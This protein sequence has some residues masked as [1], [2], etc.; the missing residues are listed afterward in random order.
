MK[1][2]LILVFSDLNHDARVVRQINFLNDKYTTTVV[3]FDAPTN[4]NVEVIRIK[5]IKPRLIQK[6]ITSFF[7]LTRLFENAFQTLYDSP[8]LRIQLKQREFDL[9]IANDIECLPLAMRI[10]KSE[11]ILFDAHEFAPRHFEDKLVWRVFFQRFNQYLCK[12]YLPLTDA[13]LTVGEGLAKEY[14]KF[15]PVNPI[16]LTNANYYADLKPLPVDSKSIKLI[17]H[18][19][20]NP[21]RQLE[22]MIEMMDY[23]DE[24]F[25]LDLM[26]LTPSIANKKT[27][28][29][30]KTLKKQI[31]K[32]SRIKIID[33]VKSD[34]VVPHIHK[35]DMGI[36][37]LPPINFNYA[38]TLPNKFFDYVQARLAIAI[39]PTPEMAKLVK[40]YNL[41][42][43]SDD[44]T[45]PSLAKKINS[46]S[47]KEISS[48]KENANQAADVLSA[49]KNKKILNDLVENLLKD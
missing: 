6:A 20:A 1:K 16:I 9:I 36:F 37:L 19:A 13:M 5:R 43:V 2:I 12:K 10:K 38:N 23:V 30:L 33:P 48:Y 35:Y 28:G 39:G 18:G 17:H 32:N 8:S 27:R 11:K 41:G 15:Y 44:F 24:R 4:L 45:A 14:H 26:L 3:C 29:Y 21:S 42:I 25:T 49:E 47:D 7:L 31:Q 34:Q 46:L 22:I 40:Q